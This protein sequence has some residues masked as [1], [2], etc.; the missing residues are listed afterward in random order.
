MKHLKTFFCWFLFLVG[1]FCITG[2]G[3]LVDKFGE[4]TPEQILFHLYMPLEADRRMMLSL[5]QN[6]VVPIIITCAIFLLAHHFK[7]N[8]TKKIT[9]HNVVLSVTFFTISLVVSLDRLNFFDYLKYKSKKNHFSS[10]YEEHY[11]DPKQVSISFPSNKRNLVLIFLESMETSYA[12]GFK[13]NLIPNLTKI[14]SENLSFRDTAT[15]G[16]G[17]PLFGTTWT[18][19]GVVSQMCGLPL[20]MPIHQNRF[21]QYPIFLPG[22]TCL[23]TVL[24]QN[25]Y[26]LSFLLGSRADFAGTDTFFKNHSD[27]KI[28]DLMYYRDIGK[29]PDD[30]KVFWGIEDAKLF[31]FAKEELTELSKS[32]KPFFMGMMTIDTHLSD[33]Y[34]DEKVCPKK[35]DENFKNV[36]SC[37]DMLVADFIQWIKE[38][39]FY[40]NT[41][42]VL[43]SDHLTMNTKI[44]KKKQPARHLLNVFIN[45]PSVPNNAHNRTYNPF[46]MFPTLLEATG[47]VIEGD[48]LALGTSLF[49]DTPTLLEKIPAFKADKQ[50]KLRNRIYEKLFYG[51]VLGEE[52]TP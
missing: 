7:P 18:I 37:S 21:T 6:T 22:A 47:A 9:R 5:I 32:E 14:I 50:L 11:I 41:S 40:E 8:F 49:G 3:W 2:S 26:N 10:F 13:E 16:G 12:V 19:A 30:Y 29:V 17:Y 15:I 51:R 42:V 31:E 35:Y 28:K 1:L 44:F 25:G 33:G 20:R 46:D 52:Q 4:V 27:L 45:P 48:R 34:F 38:Q 23:S 24:K 36:I 39:P 43:I